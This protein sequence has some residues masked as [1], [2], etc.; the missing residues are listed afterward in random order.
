VKGFYKWLMSD[1]RGL[2]PVF[3]NYAEYSTRIST[4]SGV[5]VSGSSFIAGT[6]GYYTKTRDAARVWIRAKNPEMLPAFELAADQYYAEMGNPAYRPPETVPQVEIDNTTE[7]LD[8][9]VDL[10]EQYKQHALSQLRK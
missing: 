7:I 9:E 5:T 4:I 3:A 6:F 10:D 2:N 1:G 8:S